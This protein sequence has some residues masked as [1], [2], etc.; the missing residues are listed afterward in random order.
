MAA[1]LFL[2]LATIAVANGMFIANGIYKSEVEAC[3]W[4]NV[5]STR[6]TEG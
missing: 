5:E 3:T 1:V 2:L 4:L 6:N